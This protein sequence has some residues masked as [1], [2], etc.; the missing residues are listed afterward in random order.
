MAQADIT[1]TTAANVRAELARGGYSAAGV[2]NAIGWSQ[3]RL[4]RRLK[5]ETPFDVNELAEIAAFLDLPLA[6]LLP[7]VAA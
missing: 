7:G 4:A 2:A 6:A 5:G 3:S 1:A